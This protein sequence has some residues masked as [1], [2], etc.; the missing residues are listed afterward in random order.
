MDQRS[1]G[2]PWRQHVAEDPDSSDP[3]VRR[4]GLGVRLSEQERDIL[5]RCA[6]GWTV[7]AV[8]DAMGLTSQVVRLTL[9]TTIVKIGA[10]S[11][12]EAVM[13]AVRNGLIDL[14]T[15]SRRA[16]RTIGALSLAVLHHTCGAPECAS[17]RDAAIVGSADRRET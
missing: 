15:E 2:R 16:M 10:R 17:L 8:A 12:T 7:A 5:A 3:I 1:Q 14:P 11:K 4:C 6:T 13:I 9:A